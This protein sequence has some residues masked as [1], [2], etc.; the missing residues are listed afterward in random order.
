MGIWL[1]R[2]DETWYRCLVTS[3]CVLSRK[4]GKYAELSESV[5]FR[6]KLKYFTDQNVPKRGPHEN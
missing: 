6:Q 2:V 4:V 1:L 3:G 5:A